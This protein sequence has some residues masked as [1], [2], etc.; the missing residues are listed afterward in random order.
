M[1]QPAGSE[2]ITSWSAHFWEVLTNSFAQKICRKEYARF[3][4]EFCNYLGV[5]VGTDAAAAA[6]LNFSERQA[7][8]YKEWITAAPGMPAREGGSST[9]ELDPAAGGA[10]RRVFPRAANTI[11]KRLRIMARFYNVLVI[12]GLARCN[13]FGLIDIPPAAQ[14]RPTEMVPF[15]LV[16]SII[17]AYAEPN[18]RGL[19]N[20]ALVAVLFGGALR[21]GEAHNLRVSDCQLSPTGTPFLKLRHTKAQVPQEQPLPAWAAYYLQEWLSVRLPAAGGP[22]SFVFC[23]L[24]R[25]NN[26]IMDAQ[27]N[28]DTIR[29]IFKA[30][31]SRAGL[32]PERFSPH[33][34]RATSISKLLADGVPHKEVKDF[35]RHQSIEMVAWYDKRVAGLSENP[36]CGLTF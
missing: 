8:E 7:L 3:L 15:E 20:R 36:G 18:N 21:R 9:V 32:N 22:E 25:W 35:S 29:N 23:K 13:P 33:S 6:M 30:A 12:A 4:S 5:I 11:I 19:R 16:R 31:C 28:Y 10:A 1:T 2:L 14:K 27:V 34:A 17:E 26:S 24:H